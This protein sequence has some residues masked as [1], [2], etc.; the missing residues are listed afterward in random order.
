[1]PLYILRLLIPFFL[2]I[3]LLGSWYS[4]IYEHSVPSCLSMKP[5][6]VGVIDTGI[7]FLLDTPEGK[8]YVLHPDIENNISYTPRLYLNNIE[9]II[10]VL[11]SHTSI[12]IV[13]IPGKYRFIEDAAY[14][15][16]LYYYQ[17]NNS[18]KMFDNLLKHYGKNYLFD[19]DKKSFSSVG[20][21]T[22]SYIDSC[23]ENAPILEYLGRIY[24]QDV[25]HYGSTSL[26]SSHSLEMHG[27]AVSGLITQKNPLIFVM[28][29]QSFLKNGTC[30]VTTFL[31]SLLILIK[32]KVPIVCMSLQIPLDALSPEMQEVIEY[33]IRL[34]PYSIASSGNN[35]LINNF[36]SF[37]SE[38]TTFSVGA[39]GYDEDTN[40]Y[41]ISV[42]S[43]YSNMGPTF[44]MP[45]ENIQVI[46]TY[47]N[48]L[49]KKIIHGY[50]IM[51]GT[52]F[53]AA[54]FTHYIAYIY[55]YTY[56]DFT[57]EEIRYLIF[58][59]GKDLKNQGEWRKKSIFGTLDISSIF[60]IVW[61]LQYIKNESVIMRY[62]CESHYK[63]CIDLMHHF[64]KKNLNNRCMY[65][66]EIC[67]EAKALLYD[68]FKC[69]SSMIDIMISIE[70]SSRDIKY[71]RPGLI[72][73]E[74]LE[75]ACGAYEAERMYEYIKSYRDYYW[76]SENMGYRV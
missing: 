75:R 54:L 44:V 32:N 20:Y 28:M 69:E 10:N 46:S 36:L 29:A 37:P 9:K 41:P 62:F 72:S 51:S 8:K 53:S 45:G 38:I 49:Y 12:P 67:N 2:C 76:S 14:A 34:I 65:S 57:Y 48:K 3:K 60:F 66:K 61:I 18:L 42:F 58:S 64:I 6:C 73:Y 4:D 47:Y 71:V 26:H 74:K 33:I 40:S 24:P 5:V 16:S 22:L 56:S 35:A 13:L 1:M 52:S 17:N 30:S 25:I 43:Q 27:T 59:S 15:A 21:H 23:L 63:K 11:V 70:Q 31:E 19:K 50:S 39:F 7:G 68:F 55:G